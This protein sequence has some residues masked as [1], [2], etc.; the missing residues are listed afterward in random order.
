MDTGD[1]M[2]DFAIPEDNFVKMWIFK[3]SI[4]MLVKNN[5]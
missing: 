4:F 1:N 2:E 5:I 3:H